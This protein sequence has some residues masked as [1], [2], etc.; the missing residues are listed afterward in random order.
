[1]T[2]AAIAPDEGRA[3][4]VGRLR[5]YG[6]WLMTAALLAYVFHSVPLSRTW[7]AARAAGPTVAVVMLLYF[8]YSF[9]ADSVATWATFRWFCAPVALAEVFA[10]RAATYLLAVVNY[11]LGQGG[12]VYVVG[13]RPGVGMA[14]ATGTVL[15]TMG[16]TFVALLVLAAI[17]SSLGAA[18]Q[19]RLATMQLVSFGGLG[20][21]VIYLGFVAA[22]PRFL[23]RRKLLQPLFDAGVVGHAKAWLVRFPHVAG[24]V[25]FQWWILRVFDVQI[26]FSVAASLLPII[27]VIGWLPITVQ[28]LG[29]QQLAAM[30][31]LGPYALAASVE[32][33]HA[34][35][36]AFSLTVTTLFT[37]YSVLVGLFFVRRVSRDLRRARAE[38][39]RSSAPAE[40]SAELTR[41]ERR[42]AEPPRSLR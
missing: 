6:A 26:P 35:I 9:V 1:V 32:L 33:Q 28:G 8:G 41:T 39:E 25:V 42:P 31:L 40:P 20:A 11:N 23:S 21:F 3:S 36:V 16:V 37:L 18:D 38:A 24:H 14:R 15:L 27:F 12:I 7:E 5:R 2:V 13:R 19:T 17:G 34:R 4:L 30:E 10:I 22:R 29:T